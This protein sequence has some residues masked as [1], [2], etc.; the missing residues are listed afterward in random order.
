MDQRD[1]AAFDSFVIKLKEGVSLI[2]GGLTSLTTQ[3]MKL[4]PEIFHGRDAWVLAK[5]RHFELRPYYGRSEGNDT[6]NS[7]FRTTLKVRGEIY[8]CGHVS[9]NRRRRLF[10]FN[11][12][13]EMFRPFI[14][15]NTSNHPSDISVELLDPIQHR[16]PVP[17]ELK[18]V[19]QQV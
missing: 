10:P 7:F 18:P 8:D 4:F 16:F 9:T 1:P 15:T 14:A 2:D 19:P 12:P 17:L 13:L 3:K 6:V 11:Q 5:K